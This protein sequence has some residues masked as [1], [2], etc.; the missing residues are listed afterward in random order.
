VKV[1]K[2][3][4]TLITSAVRGIVEVAAELYRAPAIS[5]E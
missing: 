3:W 4:K 1:R 2:T 5:G